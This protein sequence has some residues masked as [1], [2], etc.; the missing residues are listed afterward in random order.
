M[1]KL[2]RK[3]FPKILEVLNLDWNTWCIWKDLYL[4]LQLVIVLRTL[5]EVIHLTRLFSTFN[6]GHAATVQ[7]K[8]SS[9]ILEVREMFFEFLN[10]L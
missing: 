3:N 4:R 2:T 8:P 9:Y 1:S 5:I 10:N 7:D 6:L